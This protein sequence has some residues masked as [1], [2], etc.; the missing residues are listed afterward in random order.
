METGEE[1]EVEVKGSDGEGEDEEENKE[2]DK[3]EIK[4]LMK[5]E[6]IDLVPEDVDVGEIDK[7][8]G[9]PKQKG[10]LKMFV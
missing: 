4:D 9:V 8:T 7:L 1:E 3:Q 2:N 10:K 5:G 6:G